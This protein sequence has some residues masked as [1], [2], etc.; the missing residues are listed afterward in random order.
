MY[1]LC[2]INISWIFYG[3]SPIKLTI[4]GGMSTF[5]G[6]FKAK[7]QN[8]N[9]FWGYAKIPRISKVYLIFFGGKL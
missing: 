7:V 5:K 6:L 1:S 9:K 8:G 2:G 4:L 3:E